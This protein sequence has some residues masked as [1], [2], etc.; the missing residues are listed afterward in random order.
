[1]H[2]QFG[3]ER[4]A[5]TP[6][7]LGLALAGLVATTMTSCVAQE[8][9]DDAHMSAKHWQSQAIEQSGRIAEL[10]EQNRL[11]RAELEASDIE[12]MEASHT[13][14]E[15]L[16]NLRA[17]LSELGSNPGD[18][19]KFKVDGGYVYRVKDSILFDFASAQI[20]EAGKTVLQE[21]AADINSRPHGKVYVRGH[22][23]SVPVR[24]A[25]TLAK[26]PHGNLQLSAARAVEVGGFLQGPGAVDA[27]RLVVMG[28]GPSEP[29]APNDTDTNRQ[30]NRR[31]EIFVSDEE[32]AGDK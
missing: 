31:V 1:M 21:V 16:A 22:T 11:L 5:K 23:D 7:I 13:Y 4:G 18:V 32:P 24:R 12:A 17:T 8:T 20:S 6:R 30:K 28:F 14:D 26:F 27:N 9:Y 2:N 10:E 19:T 25:E 3:A 29:V 15:R